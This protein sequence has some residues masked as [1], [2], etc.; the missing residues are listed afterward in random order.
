M[1][2]PDHPK[3]GHAGQEPP[4]SEGEPLTLE[5]LNE[6]VQR[7]R[8]LL[9]EGEREIKRVAALL[10][11]PIEQV[12]RRSV[13]RE[14]MADWCETLELSAPHWAAIKSWLRQPDR[15]IVQPSVLIAGGWR[16]VSGLEV[17]GPE[18][19]WVLDMKAAPQLPAPLPARK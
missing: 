5:E 3:R 15:W 16:D 2:Q 14:A 1:A 9:A 4:T 18:S 8:D 11:D 19:R 12:Q 13:L 6:E 7:R 10:A 17:P